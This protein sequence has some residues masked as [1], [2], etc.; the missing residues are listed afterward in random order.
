[1]VSTIV[2]NRWKFLV[3]MAT[4]ALPATLLAQ[5]NVRDFGGSN[6]MSQISGPI[7]KLSEQIPLHHLT[8]GY[9]DKNT[10]LSLRFVKGRE[11]AIGFR[12]SEGADKLSVQCHKHFNNQTIPL[13]ADCCRYIEEDKIIELKA[14]DAE[15]VH[16]FI[17]TKDNSSGYFSVF[18]Y[19]V[20][21]I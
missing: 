2:K 1:M 4:L 21:G 6:I 19:D 18:I 20:T 16:L 13:S 12:Y 15:L 8:V 14:N 7:A 17:T 3:I 5:K 11:Y 9:I 10:I